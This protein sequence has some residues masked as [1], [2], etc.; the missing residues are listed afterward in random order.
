MDRHMNVRAARCLEYGSP[1]NL[2]VESVDLPDPGPGEVLVEVHAAAVN[3]PDILIVANEYQVR[4]PLPFT[5]GSELAGVVAAVGDDV[6]DLAPGDRVFGQVFVGAF[7]EAVVMPVASVERIPA[8]IDVESAA[9]FGV[10][11]TTAYHALRSIAEVRSGD[12]VLVLGAAGGVGLAAVELAAAL[13]GRVIAAA[14]SRVKLEHCRAK[15]AAEVVDYEC[16]DLKVR[17]KAITGGGADVVI[18]PVGGAMTDPALRAT[19]WGGRYVVVGFASGEIPRIPANLILLKGCIVRGFTLQ[20]L[21]EHAA[22]DRARDRAELFEL[23]HSGA[24]RPHVSKVFG[25]DQVGKAM[26]VIA[27][28]TA[29]GKVLIDPRG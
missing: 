7:A 17:V 19:R 14:S 23:W 4:A 11:Y 5:P 22:D 8:G 24:V 12:W 20:G 2:V 29:I 26:A 3:F 6:A 1:A 9:A 10:A 16:E 21:M 13:G 28:R 18:D 27:D 15:G 25:L